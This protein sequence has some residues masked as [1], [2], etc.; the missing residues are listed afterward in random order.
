MWVMVRKFDYWDFF[1]KFDVFLFFIFKYC[2]VIRIE[3]LFYGK[4]GYGY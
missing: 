1:N 4:F 2:V 3:M